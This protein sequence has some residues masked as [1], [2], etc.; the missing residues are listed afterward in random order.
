MS[1]VA[2]PLHDALNRIHWQPGDLRRA[3]DYLPA[4]L[5]LAAYGRGPNW[6]YAALAAHAFP[7]P[8][9]QFDVRLGWVRALQ[10]PLGWDA[11]HPAVCFA[12]RPE[13]SYTS[14]D[15]HL[16][17]SYLDYDE[18]EE[19][20]LPRVASVQ[21][22]VLGGKLPQWLFTSLTVSYQMV[23]WLAVYQPMLEG[24]VVVSSHSGIPAL[25]TLM[26][27]PGQR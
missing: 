18:L 14:L 11:E 17:A 16:P 7:Q 10:L 5:P 23:P 27:Y 2:P 9:F 1:G 22:V 13:S 15:V 8:F 19:L 21:G 20:V 3:V 26:P 25:G 6:L 4:D 24:A 12:V